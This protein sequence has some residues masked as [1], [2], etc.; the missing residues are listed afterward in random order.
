MKKYELLEKDINMLIKVLGDREDKYKRNFNRFI[1]NGPRD[2]DIWNPRIKPLKYGF[3]YERS[4]GNMPT[5]NVIK[6]SVNTII[7]KLSQTRVRPFFNPVNGTYKTQRVVR[8]AQVFFDEYFDK[9]EIYRK[10]TEAVRDAMIFEYGAMWIDE[11]DMQVK[12]IKPWEY[13]FDPVELQYGKITRCFIR[14]KNY[15]ISYLKD[16]L[17]PRVENNKPFVEMLKKDRNSLVNY[18]VY[19]DL[20]AQKKM[21]MVNG[22]V[23]KESNIDFTIPPVAMIWYEPPVK[24]GV[25]TSM[26]DNLLDIQRQIDVVSHKIYDSA[27]TSPGNMIFVPKGSNINVSALTND[28]GKIYEYQPLPSG[29]TPVQFV[30]P[31]VIDPMYIRILEQSIQFAY[32][33]E[34]ISELSAQSKKPSG[35]NSGV[36]LQTMEDVESER[37]NVI[38]ENYIQFMM[39]IAIRVI[40]MFDDKD[41]ILPK[42]LGRSDIK[43]KDMKAEKENFTIQFSASSSLSKDPKVKMEQ[44]E[45]LLSMN[46][47]DPSIAASLLDMPDLQDAYSIQ[48]AAYDLCQKIVERAV[49]AD[50]PDDAEA[51]EYYEVVDINMLYKVI[52]NTMMRLDA[53]DEDLKVMENLKILLMKVKRQMEEFN[54]VVAQQQAEAQMQAQTQAMQAQAGQMQAQAPQQMAPQQ[55]PPGQPVQGPPV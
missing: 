26:V 12:L 13:F 44:I 21:H 27:E 4:A 20:Y 17:N 33:Q 8:N 54:K 46:L 28:S 55:A 32:N 53:N 52:V 7:S 25:S 35:L 50:G 41:N 38:L 9:E 1:S 36:A 49:E 16:L 40:N 19:Y 24:G 34:G 22:T 5:F 6:S 23:V 30:T 43:W 51:F 18:I 37:H 11:E 14:K 10:A 45:K 3:Y 39:G 42:S 29:G 47:I 15:P 2:E 31:P 48:T